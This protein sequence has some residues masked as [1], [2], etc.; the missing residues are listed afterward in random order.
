VRPALGLDRPVAAELQD[1]ARLAEDDGGAVVLTV[2]TSNW[3][4]SK[5]TRL[6]FDASKGL[7]P[8][9]T[10]IDASH[11]FCAY[12][13]DGDAGWAAILNVNTSNWTISKGNTFEYDTDKG[14]TPALVRINNDHHLCAYSGEG[15]DGY[16]AVLDPDSSGL[17][18]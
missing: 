18:L 17:G 5:G 16:A 4:I 6:E 8:A 10:Q 12:T 1:G 15:D 3:T 11:Y 2:N 9:L 13:G 7:T 14:K